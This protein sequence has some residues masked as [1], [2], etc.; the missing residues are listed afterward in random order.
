MVPNSEFFRPLAVSPPHPVIVENG[1]ISLA[2]DTS[3][4]R[5]FF[6]NSEKLSKSWGF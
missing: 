1:T 2:S 3:Q 5:G 4:N 6:D